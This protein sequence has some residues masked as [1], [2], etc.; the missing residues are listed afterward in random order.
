MD[1]SF[2]LRDRCGERN[3]KRSYMYGPHEKLGHL[4]AARVTNCVFLVVCCASHASYLSC[5]YANVHLNHNFLSSTSRFTRTTAGMCVESLTCGTRLSISIWRISQLF[6][7][8][9]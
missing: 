5:H 6:V 3:F 8:Y 1:S 7:R 9:E 2:D 4:R